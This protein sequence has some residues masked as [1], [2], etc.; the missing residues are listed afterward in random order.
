M[1]QML[2]AAAVLLLIPA[3]SFGSGFA[4]FETGARSF[5]MGG[6][7]AA[8][9]D[10]PAAMFWN[11]A[12]LAFQTDKG[13]Q[14]MFGVSLIAP[15]QDLY[16]Q[17][18]YPGEG[19]FTSQKSQVFPPPHFYF[20]AP[21]DDRTS[22]GISI[23]SPFGLGTWWEDDYRGRYISKRVDLETFDISPNLAF[24]LT[25]C[26]ALGIGIDYRISTIDLRRNVPLV[27]PFAQQVVDV[28]EAHIFTEGLKNDGWGWHAGLLAK[29]GKGLSL[30]LSYRS[31]VT[32][33]YE[34]K[35]SFTQYPTGNSQLDALVGS[36]IPFD[37]ELTGSTS[38]KFPDLYNVGLAWS[39]EKWTISGQWGY[40]GWSTYD[41]LELSFDGYPEFNETIG[42]NFEDA[43]RWQFGFEYRANP[44]WAFVMGLEHD[45]TPQPEEMMTPLF[46]GGDRNVVSFGLSWIKKTFRLDATYQ[47]IDM[48]ERDT[49]GNAESGY[50]ARYKGT[51]NLF[52]VS[53]GWF[54]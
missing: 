52:A 47:Y 24:K 25:E 22:F 40:M 17:D 44:Q 49:G 28:A 6:A 27:D 26:L 35:A 20:V 16:G 2:T 13:Y 41:S 4:L 30:G 53:L 36:I 19:Y 15:K 10:D 45:N 14:V 8:V 29:L 12:G 5:G 51:A 48:E 43:D 50:N 31:Q 1:R 21:L 18:P 11:P 7:F 37:S 34:G 42:G 54:F 33:N 9:A 39:N 38:I 23:L 46:A 3:M 32:V